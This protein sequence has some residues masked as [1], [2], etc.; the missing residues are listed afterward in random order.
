MY[1]TKAWRTGQDANC[2][3]MATWIDTV[4]AT[5]GGQ[6]FVGPNENV[7]LE[8]GDNGATYTSDGVHYNA[9]GNAENAAQWQAILNP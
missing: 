3:T 4:V 5:Y 7:W 9:A 6:V 1:I 8:N 2:L